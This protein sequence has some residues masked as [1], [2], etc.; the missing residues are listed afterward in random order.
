MKVLLDTHILLWY[1]NGDNKLCKNQKVIIDS[2]FNE[3]QVSIAT[4]LEIAIKLSLNKLELSNTLQEFV[5]LIKK[6]GFTILP[7]NLEH[8]LLIS[9]LEY[10]HRD[11][12]D[13]ILIAQSKTEKIVL[14]T[15]DE[16]I[17]NMS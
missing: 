12:F 2:I 13:R 5:F 7:I 10:F 15:N 4:I 9:S 16:N 3:K 6:Y 8:I 11:L 17:K 1:L 14:I